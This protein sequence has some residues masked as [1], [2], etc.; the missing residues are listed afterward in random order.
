MNRQCCVD[1]RCAFNR[2]IVELKLYRLYHIESSKSSFNRTIVELKLLPA[3]P[4]E[5]VRTT[6]NR[7]IVELKHDL[8]SY[9]DIDCFGF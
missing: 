4:S 8:G 6:F 9:L 5:N 1:C 3:Q 2:T 7:T